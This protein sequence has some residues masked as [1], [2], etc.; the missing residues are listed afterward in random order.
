ME[1]S[2]AISQKKLPSKPVL[3]VVR[4]LIVILCEGEDTETPAAASLV[5][6]FLI[7]YPR[8]IKPSTFFRHIYNESKNTR[9]MLGVLRFFLLW[10]RLNFSRDFWKKKYHNSSTRTRLRALLNI[11]SDKD[12]LNKYRAEINKINLVLI[13]ERDRMK[14]SKFSFQTMLQYS[15][16]RGSSRKS[17]NIFDFSPEIIAKHLTVIDINMFLQIDIQEFYNKRWSSPVTAPRLHAYIERSNVLASWVASN[18]LSQRNKKTQTKALTHFIL[19]AQF[20]E[21]IGNFN[22]M[23]AVISGFDLWCIS[24]LKKILV[25]EKQYIILINRLKDIMSP[26]NG[27]DA[28]RKYLNKRRESKDAEALIPYMGV[29]KRDLTFMEDGNLDMIGDNVNTAKIELLAGTLRNIQSY[30]LSLSE[31]KTYETDKTLLQR[32]TAL[33][34][35]TEDELASLSR[36]IRPQVG[37]DVSI[38]SEGSY[39]S[40]NAS[41]TSLKEALSESSEM[42]D[43]FSSLD[44]DEIRKQLG[45]FV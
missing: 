19:V 6:D 15:P 11:L 42:V 45:A 41:N 34:C 2:S 20:C 13:T 43:H 23:N 4:Y 16:V 39:L 1:S 37:E 26:E 12:N 30:Q 32:M 10:L 27:Y 22:T 8:Y 25:I 29:I 36:T 9:M 21:Q 17:V 3:D 28:Y 18:I 40:E 24:R 5:N 14:R 33:N 31:R 35:F 38:D 44:S 7:C